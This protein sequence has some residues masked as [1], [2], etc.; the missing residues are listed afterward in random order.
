MNYKIGGTLP[1]DTQLQVSAPN[2]IDIAVV[3]TSVRDSEREAMLCFCKTSHAFIIYT[4]R[5]IKTP[6]T[7]KEL[8]V[9]VNV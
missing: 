8:Y 9:Y 7:P 4:Q 5:N 2:L 6:P 3:I 1:Q